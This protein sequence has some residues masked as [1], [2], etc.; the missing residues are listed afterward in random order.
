MPTATVRE[1]EKILVSLPSKVKQELKKRAN[2]DGM[3]MSKVLGTFAEKYASGE[4][5]IAFSVTASE[6]PFHDEGEYAA[7]R[8]DF[9]AG[10]NVVSWK[11]ARKA[12]LPNKR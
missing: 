4:I 10:R 9:D 5:G 6:P 3:S 1:N 8:A 12:L 7:R 11:E 2:S